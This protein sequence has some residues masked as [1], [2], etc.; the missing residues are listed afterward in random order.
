MPIANALILQKIYKPTKSKAD[1][2]WNREQD[3]SGGEQTAME[4]GTYKRIEDNRK[5]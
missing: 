3:R 1:R 2:S 5:E 4:V